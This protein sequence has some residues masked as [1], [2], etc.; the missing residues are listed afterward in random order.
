MTNVKQFRH[1]DYDRKEKEPQQVLGEQDREQLRGLLGQ[2]LDA[3]SAHHSSRT[4]ERGIRIRNFRSEKYQLTEDLL[5]VLEERGDG[6]YV[7][8]SYDTDQYG[9]GYSPDA[10]IDHLCSVL[11]SYYDLLL[12]DQGHLSKRLDGHLRYLK[13]ILRERE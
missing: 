8:S 13:Q 9:H 6:E 3:L 12:E 2:A 10:A 11:E 1:A 7:A 5:V 4:P